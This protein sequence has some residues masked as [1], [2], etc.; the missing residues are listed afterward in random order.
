MRKLNFLGF[1][2]TLT[3]CSLVLYLFSQFVLIPYNTDLQNKADSLS[4]RTA[5]VEKANRL[6]RN[7]LITLLTSLGLD[8]S[9]QG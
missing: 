1:S 8:V 3:V 7:N 6:E 9:D 4:N 5:A 2:C